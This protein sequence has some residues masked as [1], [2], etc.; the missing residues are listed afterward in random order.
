MER[1]ESGTS[2][3]IDT[4][5]GGS[6]SQWRPEG[7]QRVS[8]ARSYDHGQDDGAARSRDLRDGLSPQTE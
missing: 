8:S 7:G 2:A 3:G 1:E 4:A 6:V 5:G